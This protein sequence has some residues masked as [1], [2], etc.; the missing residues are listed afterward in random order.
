MFGKTQK[1]KIWDNIRG[2]SSPEETEDIQVLEFV[3]KSNN[4]DPNFGKEVGNSGFDLR[5]WISDEEKDA[6]VDRTDNRLYI[7]LKPLER[8]LIH[9][10]LY[11]K[12][13]SYT[14]IQCRPRSGKSYKEGLTVINSPGTVDENYR[15]ELCILVINL[16]KDKITIKSG[17]R[18]AQGVLCPVYNSYLV[19]LKKVDEISKD[20]ERA[21]QGIGHTKDD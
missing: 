17:E 10:G 20:T 4:P 18:I 13:P 14:E 9:T 3:N 11:F 5:A 16:S 15:G 6:K 1:I 19:N 7:N 8:R 12:L 21:D 2:Y